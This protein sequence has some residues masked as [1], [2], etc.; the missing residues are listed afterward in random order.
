MAEHS[1]DRDLPEADFAAETELVRGAN[2]LPTLSNRLR[3]RVLK[4]ATTAYRQARRWSQARQAASFL[5]FCLFV[6]FVLS[7]LANLS[8]P[9][10]AWD[11]LTRDSSSDFASLNP[12]SSP[13]EPNSAWSLLHNRDFLDLPRAAKPESQISSAAAGQISDSQPELVARAEPTL[14]RD[15]LLTA[16]HHS[17][18]WDTVQAFQAVRTRSHSTLQRAFAAN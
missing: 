10:S 13:Q 2:T 7:P 8:F 16:L 4:A 5:S 9:H 18:G 17:D 6:S 14:P 11:R 3:E 12:L 1:Y 15:K